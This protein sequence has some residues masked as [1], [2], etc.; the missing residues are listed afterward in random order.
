MN[1][2]N[3]IGKGWNEFVLYG[4]TRFENE[5]NV[6][7]F[8]YYLYIGMTWDN[9]NDE[10]LTDEGATK[11]L[12]VRNF[13]DSAVEGF[14]CT[15]RNNAYYNWLCESSVI[16]PF[17]FE[18]NVPRLPINKEMTSWWLCGVEDRNTYT[19]A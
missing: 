2:V 18:V 8:Y 15:R 9:G 7:P 16:D 10:V 12:F 11:G 5:F 6:L 19:Q 14:Y 1:G 3:R 13:V 17:Y 4:D